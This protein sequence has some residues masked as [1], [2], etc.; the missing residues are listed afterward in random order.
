MGEMTNTNS[1][2]FLLPKIK[3]NKKK[4]KKLGIL[5]LELFHSLGFFLPTFMK[6]KL[7]IILD[8]FL[9]NGYFL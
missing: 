2:F 9:R 1:F 6:I 3:K 7:F 8:L 4:K 5:I